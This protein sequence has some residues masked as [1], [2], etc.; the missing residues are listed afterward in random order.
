MNTIN[1]ATDQQRQESKTGIW[2][3]RMAIHPVTKKEIPVFIAA[4]VLS[5]F[6]SGAVMGVPRH[7]ARDKIFSENMN[8]FETSLTVVSSSGK[9]NPNDEILIN[10]GK[11]DGLTVKEG[12]EAITKFLE[13]NKIGKKVIIN[14][15]RDWLVSRQRYA[16]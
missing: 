7:D 6:A 1:R 13:E 9:G 2:T 12:R 16:H 3:G 10:S 4:Y 15:L 14:S 11:F 5:D 8:I